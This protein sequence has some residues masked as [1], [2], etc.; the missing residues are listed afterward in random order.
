MT[1]TEENEEAENG[2]PSSASFSPASPE[3]DPRRSRTGAGIGA[4][5]AGE[6]PRSRRW[7]PVAFFLLSLG[8][9]LAA[10]LHPSGTEG[11]SG[12]DG[13]VLCGGRGLAD[14]LLNVLLFLPLGASLARLR[15]SARI[16]LPLAAALS[17]GVEV[18]QLAVP[19]RDPSP[20]D[21][22]FNVAGA[23]L[24]WL[25][26]R[27]AERVLRPPDAAAARLSLG[28]SVLFAAA[29]ALTGWLTAPSVPPAALF[30]QWTPRVGDLARY[31][32]RVLAARVGTSA[33]GPMEVRDPA[34]VREALR[35][36]ATTEAVFVA[37]P[38]PRSLAP[39][40][41]MADGRRREIA[42]FAADGSDAVFGYR[43]RAADV[44]LDHP[45]FRI[46]GALRGVRPGDTVRV[47][48]RRAG[49]R[50]EAT[51]NGAPAAAPSLAAGRGW[52]LLFYSL[53]LEERGLTRVLDALWTAL[54]LAPLGIWLRRRAA[55]YAAI[56]IALAALT[57]LPPLFALPLAGIAEWL[58]AAVGL[59]AGV[60]VRRAMKAH[61]ISP[62][63]QTPV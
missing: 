21:L 3:P 11:A 60:A 4:R 28:W 8:A 34:P 29:V 48:W 5:K 20:P 24:G 7:M 23:V 30:G 44:R 12:W 36:G 54:W 10:T 31:E 35:N 33:I 40:F 47:A 16:G 6:A 50:I 57:L 62:S 17:A 38:P 41:R 55:S 45:H 58:G 51:V 22:L 14:A 15:I 49:R 52:S 59:A 2:D 61:D 43:M 27:A 37:G 46:P 19:G 25:M 32:G 42:L 39:V 1:H 18:A 63:A 56:G 13:C 53:A 26:G 9:V